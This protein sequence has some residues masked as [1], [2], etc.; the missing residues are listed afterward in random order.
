MFC[1]KLPYSDNLE[2]ETIIFAH[3]YGQLDQ[4][5]EYSFVNPIL[6]NSEIEPSIEGVILK[7]MALSEDERY[8]DFFDLI[9]ALEEIL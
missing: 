8:N 3:Q 1:G 6:M 5:T 7:L 9:E 2:E 4:D